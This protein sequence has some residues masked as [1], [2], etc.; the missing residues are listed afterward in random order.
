MPKCTYCNKDFE[1]PKGVTIVEG[2]SGKSKYFCS[3]K[4]RKNSEMG[5]KKK[6]W[7]GGKPGQKGARRRKKKASKKKKRR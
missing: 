1:P 6:K 4:C 7:A 3:S 5:R 2:I